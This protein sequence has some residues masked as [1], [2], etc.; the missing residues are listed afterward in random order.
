MSKT[1]LITGIG[2][3]VGSYLAEHL[4]Q[5]GYHVC[6][7]VRRNSVA[8]NQTSRLEGI[9]DDIR[10]FYGDVTDFSSLVTAMNAALPDE[11]YN[12]A[13]QSHVRV[14]ADCPHFTFQTNAQGA[15]NV[16]EAMRQVCPGARLLQSSS[17]E[18]FGNSIDADGYQRVTTPMHPTSVYGVSKLAAYHM[19][20]HYRRAHGMFAANTICFNMESPR[21]GAAFVTQKIVKGAVRIKA[22]LQHTLALGNLDAQRDWG[23]AKDYARAM[24]LALQHDE[25]ADWV[26]ASGETRSVRELCGFVFSHLDMDWREHVTFDERY[27]RPEELHALRGHSSATRHFLGWQP[28][29]TFEQLIEEM[30]DHARRDSLGR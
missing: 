22:G 8:E 1:A 15:L 17:S 10:L 4:L 3:Q 19:V 16:I 30:I 24:I 23:H 29:Y 20:R 5:R 9:I 2:G 11:V 7:I 21:R 18:M 12:L 25:P 13:A 27:T 14:S 6:G 28:E 26:V